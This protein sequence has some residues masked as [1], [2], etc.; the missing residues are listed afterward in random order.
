MSD[1]ALRDAISLLDQ[2]IS[3][4]KD[5]ITYNDV[6][7]VIGIVN[8]TFIAELADNIL[9]RDV[10][11]MLARIE[12][13]VMDG[14]D[15]PHF[16]SDLVHYFRNLLICGVTA[17]PGDIIELPAEVVEVMKGQCCKTTQE[18]IIYIIKELSLLESGLKWATNPR[19]MLEVTLVKLCESKAVSVDSS[20]LERLEALEK[21]LNSG[22]MPP[23]PTASG[24]TA[25]TPLPAAAA[26]ATS[27][28]AAI[29]KQAAVSAPA[30]G[31]R[32]K[33]TRK[34]SQAS[35]ALACTACKTR[36]HT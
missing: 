16:I 4:G 8:D 7:S 14:K 6:L 32:R 24:V 17:V 26:A 23:A 29:G 36:V 34:Y 10:S 22:A 12:Q 15:I 33:E 28:A 21:R 18:E 1:G 25:T 30:P 3:L 27:A 5:T 31:C 19:I 13:L 11:G 35:E 2:C 9:D 20:I